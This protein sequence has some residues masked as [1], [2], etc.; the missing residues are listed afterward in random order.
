[1]RINIYMENGEYRIHVILYLY[2]SASIFYVILQLHVCLHIK[3]YIN[4]IS[5]YFEFRKSSLLDILQ[6]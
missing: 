3:I 5:L 1:M 4:K 6:I 2:L